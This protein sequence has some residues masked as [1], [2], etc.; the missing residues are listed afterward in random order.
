MESVD[1][2]QER[3]IS[4]WDTGVAVRPVGVVVLVPF[5]FVAVSVYV[6]VEVG[7]T[8]VEPESVLVEKL[9]GVIERDVAFA[10]FQESVD[11]PDGAT[12]VGDAEKE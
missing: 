4:V 12:S 10:T 11:D 1:V 7:F 5:A 3:S 8:I 9:P 6:V 2:A